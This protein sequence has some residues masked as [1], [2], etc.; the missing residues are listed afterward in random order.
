MLGS[1]PLQYRQRWEN[2]C[3]LLRQPWQ[4]QK[5]F[6]LRCRVFQG[7]D[8]PTISS[9]FQGTTKLA[10]SVSMAGRTIATAAV[11]NS[12]GFVNWQVRPTHPASA[13]PLGFR[14]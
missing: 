6:V 5:R 4:A 2:C 3:R 12:T 14:I 1:R 9:I 11:A 8:L 13:G 7:V 10:V